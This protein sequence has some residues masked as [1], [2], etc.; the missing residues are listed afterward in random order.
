MRRDRMR[1]RRRIAPRSRSCSNS[2]SEAG[3]RLVSVTALPRA[4]SVVLGAQQQPGAGGIEP[5]DPGQ[6][7][8]RPRRPDGS[9]ERVQPAD[10]DRRL[11]STSQSPCG[12]QHQRS[13]LL[14]GNNRCGRRHARHRS[15][16]D[17]LECDTARALS[18]YVKTRYPATT[19]A[20]TC[21]SGETSD[22]FQAHIRAIPDFPKPGILFYDISTL[23]AH[24]AGLARD[25]RAAGGGCGPTGPSCW[26]GSNRAAFCVAAPL[27]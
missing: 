22:G 19:A 4:A 12:L 18:K 26:S 25:D 13:R 1:R 17:G 2:G 6:R 7:R 11:R 15:E 10:R 27:A 23:L 24:P 5:F 14:G 16:P 21:D 8:S 9:F 20:A 3:R